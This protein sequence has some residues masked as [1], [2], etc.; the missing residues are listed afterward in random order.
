MRARTPDN[1]VAS[2][3]LWA[4][5][6]LTIWAA[7]PV[8][9]RLAV[10]ESLTPADIVALRFGVGGLVL[11]PVLLWQ[12]RA[13]PARAWIEGILLA[14]CQGAP[15]A[16]LL[17]AGLVNAPA[18]HAAALTPGVAPL[19]A[20]ILSV[21]FFK[22]E[23][24]PLRFAGYACIVVGA[25]ALVASVVA[26]DSGAVSI[27]HLYFVSAAAI[28][29]I[30]TVRVGRS[31]LSATQAAAI[32]C[33]YSA[34]MLAPPYLALTDWQRLAALPPLELGF[35]AAFQG[36]AMGAVSLIALNRAIFYLGAP[37]AMAVL[38]LLPVVTMLL[39]IPLLGEIP[40]A[41]DILA[42]ATI[43]L[44]VGLATGF[45]TSDRPRPTVSPA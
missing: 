39:G 36:V 42:I 10:S 23:A 28:V 11:L 12:A 16:F 5:V 20:Y 41:V 25:A 6:A 29:S 1:A 27:G 14:V 43:S 17:A 26:Q 35:H 19:F 7:W 21:L 32:V 44:G 34:I 33:V 37:R 45:L 24:T 2:G 22:E 30:Y 31:G 13:I 38:S 40:E 3:L 18:S 9:T 8:F 15:F 4:A